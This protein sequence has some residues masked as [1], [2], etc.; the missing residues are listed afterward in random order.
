VRIFGPLASASV[1]GDI[2]ITQSR[3]FKQID[4][5]PLE[6]PG[7]PAPPPPPAP[8]ANPSIDSPPLRDWKFALKIH[9]KD[10]FL[11]HGNLANGSALVDLTIGGTGKA[12]TLEGSV[13][14]ENFVASLPFSNLNVTNG[15]VYFTKDDP[16]VPNLNIQATSTMQDYNINVYIY[17][18]A[19]DPKTVMSSEPPLRQED[20]VSLLATGATTS[21]LNS[22]TG[23]AGRAAV[24][25][26]QSV[27]HKVFK[28][29]PPAGADNE[30][31]SSR[32]KVDVG[33]VDSRTGQQ[34]VSS[35]FKLSK[36][37]YLVGD[38]DVGGDLRGTIRYLIRFK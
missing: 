22:G 29:K 35:S 17:G 7:K 26:L 34:E 25:L 11:I 33:G 15:F 4:I 27:Y 16:F 28:S 14:I 38:V 32:F 3:F 31:F 36:Q 23:I 30:S 10:P 18:T 24:L 20:I 37:L 21:N 13:R 2:G 12:P 8:P 1:T 6:L 5:L 19:S 9:T